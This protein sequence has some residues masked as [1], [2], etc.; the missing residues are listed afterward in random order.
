MKF[1]DGWKW[2]AKREILTPSPVV[3]SGFITEWTVAGDVTARTVT[4]PLYD[5]GTF[6]CTV[7]WGDGTAESTIASYNDANRIHVYAVDG[8]YEI[9]IQGNCPS[10]SFNDAGDKLKITDIINWGDDSVFG[11]FSYLFNGFYGCINLQ[12]LGTGVIGISGTGCATFN[13]SFMGCLLITTITTGLFDLHIN[14]STNGFAGTFYGWEELTA[15]PI[16]LFRYNV[17]ASGRAFVSTFSGCIKLA[18][19]P[20]GLFEYNVLAIK[21]GF[22]RTFYGC[23]KLQ[24][25]AWIFYASGDEDTRFLNQSPDFT[26]CFERTS[27]TGTQGTA[28]ALWDCSFG[29]GTEVSTD[30]F[31]GAGNSLTSL[32]N[33]ASIPSGWRT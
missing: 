23:N 18:S 8:T 14:V 28:P 24:L 3:L 12:S 16:D 13:Q 29:T 27:F 1:V 26:S 30:C 32:D 7:D 11:G 33:Y 31:G 25:N 6:N 15:I 10:W 17:L 5:D 22:Y 2:G 19:V 9:E 20:E 4:L 21:N